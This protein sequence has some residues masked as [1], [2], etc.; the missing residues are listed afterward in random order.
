MKSFL[1]VALALYISF[2]L[3]LGL[4][5]RLAIPAVNAAGVAYIAMTWPAWVKGSPIKLHI[6]RWVFTFPSADG[7]AA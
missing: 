2:G 4:I 6:P 5:T 7:R 3:C 1:G